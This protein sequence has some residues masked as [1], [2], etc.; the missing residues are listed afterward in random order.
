MS[1]IPNSRAQAQTAGHL[2]YRSNTV[3]KSFTDV[4]AA[5][6][7]GVELLGCMALLVTEYQTAVSSFVG[8]TTGTIT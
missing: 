3:T 7:F 6:S 4:D 8:T 2:F 5:V 1:S